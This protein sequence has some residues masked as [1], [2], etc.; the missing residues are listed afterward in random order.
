MKSIKIITRNG[1]KFQ[2]TLDTEK[3]SKIFSNFESSGPRNQRWSEMY[4]HQGKNENHFYICEIS[5]WE[6]EE[7]VIRLVS[8]EKAIEFLS[9]RL[10]SNEEIEAMKKYGLQM[11]EA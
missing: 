2:L 8:R 5:R 10:L 3:D 4:A 6:N 9:E 1:K 11:E 7:S